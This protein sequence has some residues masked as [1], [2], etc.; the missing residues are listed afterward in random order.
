MRTKVWALALLT[1][2]ATGCA[3]DTAAQAGPGDC[4]V[5]RSEGNKTLSDDFRIVDCGA[6]EAAYQVAMRLDSSTTHCGTNTYGYATSSQRRGSGWRL[7]LSLNAKVGDCFHQEVGF[8]TGRAGKVACGPSAT[9]RVTKVIEGI[10]SQDACGPDA[11]TPV[12]ND[13]SRPLVLAYPKPP[14]TICTDGI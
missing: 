13:L 11:V 7:C 12:R 6:P 14:H 8:P 4:M 9:Y 1:A 2:V 10:D 5:S 3:D